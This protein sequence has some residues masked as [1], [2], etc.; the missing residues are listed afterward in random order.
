MNEEKAIALIR[1]YQQG[2][3]SQADQQRLNEWYLLQAAEGRAELSPE[4]MED[5]VQQIRSRLPLL[6]KKSI[7]L[8]RKI[9]AVAA[10]VLFGLLGIYFFAYRTVPEPSREPAAAL[11]IL[12]GKVGA[13][14]TLASGKK[15]R[16][17]DAA[18][19]AIAVEA[20]ITVRKSAEGRLIYQ[21]GAESADANPDALNTLSTIAGETFMV[22]LPDQSRVWLNSASSISYP[23]ALAGLAV[24]KVRISGEAYFEIAKDKTRPFVVESKGQQVE[25][26]GTHFNVNGYDNELAT[27]TTLLEGR[28]KI[29]SGKHTKIINPGEQAVSSEAGI[30]VHPADEE[31]V[32]DWKE[33]DFNLNHVDFKSAMRKIARWYNIE[34]IYD[35]DLPED[36][37]TGGWISRNNKLSVVL[38]LIESSGQVHFKVQGRKVFVTK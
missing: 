37:E 12:P 1:K 10:L 36:I 27:A 11:D 4:E 32:T 23:L 3:L 2:T 6:P 20:G 30:S 16:L 18:S 22:V 15:I 29:I 28:I 13:T 17:S 9:A 14:L 34:V 5:T 33:G 21:A 19:G 8:W 26:L 38:K 35:K 24:R 31:N 25:V 7:V